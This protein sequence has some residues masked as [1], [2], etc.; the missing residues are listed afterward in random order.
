MFQ[1]P[2]QQEEQQLEEN[3]QLLLFSSTCQFKST[4]TEKSALTNF[5]KTNGALHI[6]EN[7]YS[8]PRTELFKL[9][10]KANEILQKNQPTLKI[11]VYYSILLYL[12]IITLGLFLIL[13]CPFLLVISFILG[14]KY[15]L[16][17]E[18]TIK[19][20]NNLIDKEKNGYLERG[21]IL[22]FKVE[23]FTYWS[24]KHLRVLKY[25]KINIYGKLNN[26]N[27]TNVVTVDNNIIYN[28]N[29]T[30]TTMTVC[31][32]NN[33]EPIEA[34]YYSTNNNNNTDVT[35]TTLL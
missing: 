14:D 28:E 8:L 35:T 5:T 15:K 23:E 3:K 7:Y 10:D 17:L 27:T 25:F 32:E 6:L 26:V 12:G 24:G 4:S 31:N 34:V 2:Q 33:K 20:I 13:F 29:N 1:Q 21:L 9:I 19:E 11:E 30:S 22:E 18:E 16:N